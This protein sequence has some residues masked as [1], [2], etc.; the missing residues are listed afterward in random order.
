MPGQP[1]T[2]ARKEAAR[3][4]RAATEHSPTPTPVDE[5]PDALPSRAR[6]QAGAHHA[7]ESVPR[8]DERKP[9]APRALR[10]P[11]IG[12]STRAAVDGAQADTML[13]LASLIR[14]GV[15]IR[16][17]RV[18]PTW[19]AGWIEDYPTDVTGDAL[20]DLFEHLRDEH[21]GQLYRLTILAPG[22]QP[23]YVGAQAIAGP[24]RVAGR[25]TGRDAFE[26]ATQKPTVER[27]PSSSSSAEPFPMGAVIQGFVSFMQTMMGQQ[28]KAAQLQIEAVRDMVRSSQKQGSDLANAVLAHRADE[29]DQRG[30][31]GQVTELLEGME[32]VDKVRKRFGAAR[33]SNAEPDGDEMSGVLKEAAKSF[34]GNVMGSVAS[35]RASQHAAAPPARRVVRRIAR[36][37]RVGE[38]S[39]ELLDA[40]AGQQARTN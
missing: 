32:A 39:T 38:Q 17:E 12:A 19:A 40:I 3:R 6:A 27:A 21:G 20:G 11:L 5:I 16:I 1:K 14:P 8:I 33:S 26:L 22:E 9:N 30:L 24:V 2:R 34:L 29:R 13:R 4:A 28:E 23:L 7:R 36:P 31:A 25:S 18:R 37:A 10:S 35:Q 15:S